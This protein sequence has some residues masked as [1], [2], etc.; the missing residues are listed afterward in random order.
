MADETD[1]TNKGST[2][3]HQ[4]YL[5]TIIEP[6]DPNSLDTTIHQ[7]FLDTTKNSKYYSQ[8][9][10][11]HPNEFDIGG[12][13]YY[14]NEIKELHKNSTVNFKKFPRDWISIHSLN[15][16]FVASNPLNGI[17]VRY[18]LTDSSFNFYAM[19]SDACAISKIIK[20]TNNELIAELV[21]YIE[22]D[23]TE[24]VYL[25]IAQSDIPLLYTIEYS[26]TKEF[27]ET[28]FVRLITPLENLTQF[29]LVVNDAPVLNSSMVRFEKTKRSDVIRE[30]VSF[31]KTNEYKTHLKSIDKFYSEAREFVDYTIDNL[32]ED[33]GHIQFISNRNLLRELEVISC[34]ENHVLIKDTLKNGELCEIK[35]DF[36]I[37]Q[38]KDHVVKR[39]EEKNWNKLIDGAF[40]YGGEYVLPQIEITAFS[41]SIDGESLIINKRA[42]QNL[43]DLNICDHF[44]WMNKVE[45]FQSIDG[46]FIYIYIS[47]GRAA[48]SYFS[49]LIFNKES[50]ITK[51]VAPYYA[52]SSHA[53]F[54]SSFIGF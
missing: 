21:E 18:V 39:N 16:Q 54:R 8:I 6:N 9:L 15:Q 44:V 7:L 23:S 52:L 11:W 1:D 29:N 34:D 33:P 53:S 31:L 41:I 38:P 2:K 4:Q 46:E 25:K 10:N 36:G 40:P 19:E 17:D 20:L 24:I 14:L 47:G 50:F 5:D 48:S 42:Y 43:F 22:E 32:L 49:K 37:F 12:T 3:I 35:L 13:E 27:V 51:I 28:E 30:H 26:G 45:A